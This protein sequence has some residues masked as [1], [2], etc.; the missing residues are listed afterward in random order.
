MKIALQQSLAS[1]YQF[2][3]AFENNMRLYAVVHSEA[4]LLYADI[5]NTC[6]VVTFNAAFA[7]SFQAYFRP[8]DDRQMQRFLYREYPEIEIQGFYPPLMYFNKL[9]V[10]GRKTNNL[11]H[12]EILFLKLCEDQILKHMGNKHYV[13]LHCKRNPIVLD[14]SK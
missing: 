6:F 12:Y 7:Q 8:Y 13:Y 4:A 3:V 10:I 5:H 14:H 11:L 9:F 1:K 2:P